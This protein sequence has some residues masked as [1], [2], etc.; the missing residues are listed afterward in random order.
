MYLMFQATYIIGDPFEELIEKG[1]TMLAQFVAGFI[2]NYYLASFIC[3][4]IIGGVGGVIS[5]LPIIVIIFLCLSILEDCG[6]LARAAFTMDIFM[7][8]LVGLHG[9]IHSDDFRI[10]LWCSGY[11]GNKGFGK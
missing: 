9:G 1:F 10:R 2:P 11:Y 6:Y 8:K 7:H 3:D 5:F 4:G